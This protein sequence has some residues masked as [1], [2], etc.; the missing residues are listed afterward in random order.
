MECRLEKKKCGACLV[1][2][3]SARCDFNEGG[4]E[5]FTLNAVQNGIQ[6]RG[7]T[8]KR[9]L[10]SA[11]QKHVVMQNN[12]LPVELEEC[13]QTRENTSS[14]LTQNRNFIFYMKKNKT[15]KDVRIKL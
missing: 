11:K 4:D 2:R 10:T 3:H 5:L 7:Q 1:D 8:T 6:N 9:V 13:E 12:C 15:K 14:T